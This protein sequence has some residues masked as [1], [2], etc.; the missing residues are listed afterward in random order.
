[1]Y[2]FIGGVRKYLVWLTVL[3]VYVPFLTNL[4]AWK[5][6]CIHPKARPNKINGTETFKL[7]QT[8]FT[9][10]W[11]KFVTHVSSL[12]TFIYQSICYLSVH[13]IKNKENQ[14]NGQWT[15]LSSSMLNQ[16]QHLNNTTILLSFKQRQWQCLKLITI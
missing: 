8:I 15:D 10:H 12:K 7:L 2:K 11:I 9:S 5:F 4:Y 16:V 14:R 6:K 1:M 13:E 3:M